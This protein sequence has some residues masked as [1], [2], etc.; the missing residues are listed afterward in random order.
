MASAMDVAK[1]FLLLAKAEDELI[2]NLKL[3][4]LLYYA[5]G[6]SLAIRGEPAFTD[7]V[8]AWTLGPVVPAVYYEYKGYDGNPLP[9]PEDTE[10]PGEFDDAEYRGV[11]DEVNTVFG[12]FSAW[13]LVQTTH[14]EPPWRDTPNGE[15][16][17]HAVLKEYFGKQLVNA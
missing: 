14:D 16:I 15:E 5:Q 7:H 10:L 9:Y 1:Y 17:T 6:F 3:Q 2:S 4:K 11:L 13:R 12:Q 8:D